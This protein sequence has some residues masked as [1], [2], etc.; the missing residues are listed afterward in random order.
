[1]HTKVETV[2]AYNVVTV[3]IFWYIIYCFILVC[4]MNVH[5]YGCID[6][7]LDMC[8]GKKKDKRKINSRRVSGG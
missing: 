8:V 5:R 2:E 1:M 3:S 4:E 7:S 6:N